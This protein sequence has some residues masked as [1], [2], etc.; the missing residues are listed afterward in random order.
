MKCVSMRNRSTVRAIVLAWLV[1]G[2]TPPRDPA[3]LAGTYVA[4]Q[5]NW[6]AVDTLRLSADARYVRTYKADEGVP[7]TDSGSWFLSRD[8]RT[9]AL[10][11]YPPRWRFVHDLMGDTTN[12][13]I[14]EEPRIISL[15]IGRSWRGTVRLGW[16][17]EWGWWYDRSAP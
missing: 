11:A 6:G 15:T 5:T 4:H 10:K 17:P 16:R 7:V 13:R 9:V 14:L 2:C 12:G 8:K 3:G 1:A